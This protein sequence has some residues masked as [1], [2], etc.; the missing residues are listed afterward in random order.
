MPHI[1]DSKI[2]DLEEK[3][4]KVRELII[5]MLV[6]AGSG[7]SAGPLDMADIFVALYFH[8]MHHDIDL[9]VL[10]P[11]Y[12]QIAPD[13]LAQGPHHGDQRFGLP[14][15]ILEKYRQGNLKENGIFQGCHAGG[16]RLVL[17]D[18]HFAEIIT[19]LDDIN[20]PVA[21]KNLDH[22]PQHNIHLLAG[23]AL[24]KKDN[25]LADL[26]LLG[27]FQKSH[28][29]SLGKEMEQVYLAQIL[30][31][32]GLIQGEPHSVDFQPFFFPRPYPSRSASTL[33]TP[34]SFPEK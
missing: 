30:Q 32:F 1:H 9:L 19:G 24:A 25:I 17:D 3:A 20:H 18:G 23:V 21:A 33:K 5:E 27:L 31:K 16:T 8:I 22:S 2:K 14:G 29:L 26:H 15:K 34:A 13:P 10:L 4:L 7:H 6:A 11:K 12:F 28:K